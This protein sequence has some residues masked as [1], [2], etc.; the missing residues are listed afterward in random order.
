MTRRITRAATTALVAGGLGVAGLGLTVGTAEAHP[1]PMPL[2]AWPGC[3]NDHPQG[4][5]H[6]CP[7]DPPVQTG[8]LRVDPV[9]W[10]AN[11][12]HTYWYVYPGQG[13]VANMIFEGDAPPPPPPPAPPG[14]I[15]R[16]NCQQIL[17]IFCPHA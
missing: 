4:P 6:W 16:D 2:N 15:N 3:P 7:G 14:L 1:G 17:G 11:V 8:N 5:C 9:R 12:C 10:D 13:N